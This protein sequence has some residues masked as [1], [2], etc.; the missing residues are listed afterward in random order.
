[1]ALGRASV[2]LE[3]VDLHGRVVE[4]IPSGQSGGAANYSG[5][6]MR[7]NSWCAFLNKCKEEKRA[8]FDEEKALRD[9]LMELRIVRTNKRGEY[10]SG[11]AKDNDP[12][13]PS[14]E[15][16]AIL[17]VCSSSDKEEVRDALIHEA[18]HGVFY[19]SRAFQKFCY[20]FW[21][22]SMTEEE[23]KTWVDFLVGLRYNAE[24]D[25]ELAVNELQAY[26]ATERKLFE[27]SDAAGLKQLQLKFSRAITEKS[28]LEDGNFGLEEA[29]TPSV[30]SSTKLVWL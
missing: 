24:N 19:I 2:F 20:W 12:W 15:Q 11:L 10:E 7:V 16:S 28:T 17:A 23:R 25:V 5:H 13:H 18:M 21:E 26:M 3:D 6:N 9:R 8:L 14:E 30:G 29:L 22:E 4:Q 1:M 27:A